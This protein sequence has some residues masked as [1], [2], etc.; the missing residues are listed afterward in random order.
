MSQVANIGAE[1]EYLDLLYRNETGWQ[2]IDYKTDG[3][4]NTVTK[5][6][7]VNGYKSQMLR[8]EK[9]GWKFIRT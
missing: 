9:N 4:H 3:I 6:N 1:S 7:L 8:Y 2:V 5:N